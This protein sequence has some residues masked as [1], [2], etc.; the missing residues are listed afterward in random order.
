MLNVPPVYSEAMTGGG[1]IFLIG[2]LFYISCASELTLVIIYNPVGFKF[3]VLA[4]MCPEITSILGDV[5]KIYR[6]KEIPK[7]S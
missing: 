3:E 5:I 4:N 6:E 1:Q 7:R 2:S